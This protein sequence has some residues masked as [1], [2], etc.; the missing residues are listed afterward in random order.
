MHRRDAPDHAAFGQGAGAH[1]LGA[2]YRRADQHAD[3][4]Q[5]ANHV[6]RMA[7]A[8][9]RQFRTAGMACHGCIDHDQDQHAGPRRRYRHGQFRNGAHAGPKFR[10]QAP[11]GQYL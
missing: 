5:H 4:D 3:A 2:Q 8:V 7:Q 9:E 1:R 6:H 10:P 11:V